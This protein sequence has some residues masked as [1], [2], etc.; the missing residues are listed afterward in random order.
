MWR[1]RLST[2]REICPRSGPDSGSDAEAPTATSIHLCPWL[3]AQ[4]AERN[5]GMRHRKNSSDRPSH[6]FPTAK[7]ASRSIYAQILNPF[8]AGA[9]PRHQGIA[10]GIFQSN[11][12]GGREWHR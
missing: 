1:G 5:R 8:G 9:T 6:P 4:R 2:C 12:R 7:T 10:E 3:I 11:G